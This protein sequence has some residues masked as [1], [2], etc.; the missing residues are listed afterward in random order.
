[1]KI[2]RLAAAA[3]PVGAAVLATSYVTAPPAEAAPASKGAILCYYDLCLQTQGINSD[4]ACVSTW[5]YNEN[6]YG[7]FELS[8]TYGWH[9]NTD[10][11]TWKGGGPGSEFYS[12]PY[13]ETGLV[14]KEWKYAD[15]K[16][17]EIA[18]IS[19]AVHSAGLNI[20]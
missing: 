8:S 19:F 12:V 16:Y 7:H 6:F 9:A 17:T 15:G 20:C 18:H 14:A 2:K 3:A 4:G 11:E 13:A 1:V 10:N 5:A